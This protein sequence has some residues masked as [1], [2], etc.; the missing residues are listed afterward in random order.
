MDLRA[1]QIHP[2][3]NWATFEDL[4][5]A[6][7]K[8]V[9]K[10]PLAQKN[11]RAGQPQHGVD[12][13]GGRHGARSRY[14][15]VQCK[16][17]T[18]HYGA[19]AT[20]DELLAEVAKADGFKPMLTHWV[21]ATTAPADAELQT[22]ARLLSVERAKAGKFTV[23]VLGWEEIQALMAT[24]PSVVRE[25]YPE[26]AYDLPA[27]LEA[28]STLRLPAAAAPSAWR[29][30]S[31]EGVRDLGPA[32]L[33]RP[34]GA[35][36]AAVCPRLVEADVLVAQLDT[37]YSARIVGDP[38][39]G[40]SVCAYQAAQAF[41]QKSA[42]V[43]R[44]DDARSAD[45]EL[46]P[47]E[48]RPG[49][50][51]FLIDDAHL[52]SPGLLAHLEASTNAQTRLL[53]IHNAVSGDRGERGA[54]ALDA[55]RAVKTIAA[56]LRSDRARTLVAV[57]KADSDVGERMMDTQLER[58]IDDA[59]AAAHYPWQFCFILGG[60]WRRAKQATDRARV[61]QA[62][63]VL[64]AVA[65]RQILSRDARV[66]ASEISSLCSAAGLEAASVSRALDWLAS[67]R[68][69][70]SLTDCRTPHQRFAAVAMHQLLIAASDDERRRLYALA[71]RL[72]I[73]PAYPLL[74]VRNLLHEFRFGHGNYRW[75]WAQPFEAGTIREL[76]DRCFAADTSEMRGQAGLVLT[77]LSSFSD[78]W[79]PEIIEP[80]VE[81]LAAWMSAP[82]CGGYGLGHLHNHLWSEH[83]PL[84]LDLTRRIDPDA[85]ALAFSR[86]SH[87]D[88]YGIGDLV[89]SAH[90]GANEAWVARMRAAFDRDALLARVRRWNER[91]D[92]WLVAHTC[93]ATAY[94]DREFAL[95][96]VEAYL[97]TLQAF[98]ALDPVA[99]F[100]D[101]R[102]IVMGVLRLDDPL[103]T[104]VGKHRP[105]ARSRAIGRA[106]CA[107]LDPKAVA[108]N[109]SKTRFRDFQGAG[110]F[111]VFLRKCAP[112]KFAAV[113]QSINWGQIEVS[114]GEEWASPP[115]ELEVMCGTLYRGQEDEEPVADFIARNANRI[116]K[117]PPRFA[118]MAPK[119]GLA[120]LDAGKPIALVKW[121]HVDWYFGTVVLRLVAEERPH[122]M[123]ALLEPHV[124]G[125]ARS[126]SRENASWFTES[127]GFL[128]TLREVSPEGLETI[129][130]AVDPVT[131]SQGWSDALKMGG[132][133]A[134]SVAV[135]VDASLSRDDE[136]AALA[137]GLRKR[138]P[139]ASRAP[140]E[141]QA[142]TLPQRRARRSKGKAGARR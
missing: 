1:K 50:A 58:R 66:T 136:L 74:G 85:L 124:A 117:L 64:A 139:V 63:G 90:N 11:G 80:K 53:S 30:I 131:A 118:T 107:G 114:I 49:V 59:E 51:L 127:A 17:K 122:L 108:A 101:V 130:D 12:V 123:A 36:D 129:L 6:L 57:R 15:G 70:L 27:V 73:D 112:Q 68:L 105:D 26:A 41:A 60:G 95:T 54:V 72:L 93:N 4:C 125:I 111:L 115:H 52:M 25:F 86:A 18:T 99:T 42:A 2:P 34:L 40:K 140:Q 100:R 98:M 38:G 62:D 37:A 116:E 141:R 81:M 67:E 121:E 33:G 22:A 89:K 24:A 10:D 77:E 126:L 87:E 78:G 21:Y 119:V 106:I 23:D 56:G 137:K 43:F 29:R 44:L 109:I 13:F 3:K 14:E 7:F 71:G 19:R 9:W 82:E 48:D 110:F 32:L 5:H 28:V 45:V 55:K 134:K 79:G 31:F 84:Q 128:C 135:L 65:I 46:M 8:I 83:K 76:A 92:S 75:A 103:G 104:F 96:L 132:E 102:D 97:P 35:A 88:L 47:T 120:H 91:E 94:Y 69:L 142:I 133:P 39:A 16:G 113:V 20:V 61:A 138:F